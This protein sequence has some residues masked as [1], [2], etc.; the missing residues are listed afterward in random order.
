M[1]VEIVRMPYDNQDA[2]IIDKFFRIAQ[3][4]GL[5]N[6]GESG[7]WTPENFKK[8]LENPRPFLG[9][10]MA[11]E[12]TSPDIKGVPVGAAIMGG[13]AA[14][15]GITAGDIIIEFNGKTVTSSKDLVEII[16]SC[17]VSDT[18]RIKVKRGTEEIELSAVLGAAPL[19]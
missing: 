3:A 4:S 9:I 12:G 15:A 2:S 11:R 13:A 16:T 6:I 10:Q 1:Y 18:V 19:Y 8:M 14:K 7:D 5:T 17:R